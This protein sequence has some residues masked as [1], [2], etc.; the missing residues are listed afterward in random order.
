LTQE[1]SH[2][3][4]LAVREL[5]I[6]FRTSR[7]VED[8]GSSYDPTPPVTPT[9]VIGRTNQAQ[10]YAELF[11]QCLKDHHSDCIVVY[12]QFSFTLKRHDQVVFQCPFEKKNVKNAYAC[13]RLQCSDNIEIFLQYLSSHKSVPDL[14]VKLPQ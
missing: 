14:M 4:L 2:E 8:R 5:I 10:R 9:K 6:Q 12:N 7:G 13:F 11:H 3:T 1:P